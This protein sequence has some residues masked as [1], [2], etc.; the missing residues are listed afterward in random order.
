MASVKI[1]REVST[2][3]THDQWTLCFQYVIYE[4]EPDDGKAVSEQRGYRFIWR[5]PNGHLQGARGQARLE[6]HLITI[7]LGKAAEEGWYPV[8]PASIAVGDRSHLIVEVEGVQW[9][10]SIQPGVAVG[11]RAEGESPPQPSESGLYFR[12]EL[13]IRFLPI[14]Y[15][16]LPTRPQLVSAPRDALRALFDRAVQ[17]HVP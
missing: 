15:P 1:L 8:P 13:G 16:D 17:A 7:L 10:I 4:Y 6:P 3:P 5:R 9:T 14:P 11:S 2:D 12:S